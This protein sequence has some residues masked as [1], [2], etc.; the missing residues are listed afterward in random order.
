MKQLRRASRKGQPNEHETLANQETRLAAKSGAKSS[1]KGDSLKQQD[2]KLAKGG[3]TK[4][5]ASKAK[6]PELDEFTDGKVQKVVDGVLEKK[7]KLLEKL[8]ED[9]NSMYS[10]SLS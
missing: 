6:V 10:P 1:V 4:G 8:G 9:W 3:R 7:S 5:K 2:A